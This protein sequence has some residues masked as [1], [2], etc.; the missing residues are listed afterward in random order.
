[1]RLAMSTG[2]NGFDGDPDTWDNSP[3][4]K[5]V[6][7]PAPVRKVYS[8]I[9]V[10]PWAIFA[11]VF[12][13]FMTAMFWNDVIAAS[14]STPYLPQNRPVVVAFTG[15]LHGM[16]TPTSL[17]AERLGDFNTVIFADGYGYGYMGGFVV[18]ILVL[19]YALYALVRML[20]RL[21]FWVIDR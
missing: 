13:I 14:D 15:F 6:E 9:E 2:N 21:A 4:W 1:M 8:Q 5:F 11:P 12:V 7:N 20:T 18:G 16:F 10:T 19:G 3:R 17:I